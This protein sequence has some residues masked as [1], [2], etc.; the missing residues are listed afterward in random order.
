MMI[1][2]PRGS[3]TDGC[4]DRGRACEMIYELL[5]FS[6]EKCSSMHGSGKEQSEMYKCFGLNTPPVLS[7]TEQELL[8]FASINVADWSNASFV[9]ATTCMERS[10]GLQVCSGC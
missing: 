7:Y 5:Q 4:W 6:G 2:W 8:D 9:A 10:V 1:T 3:K